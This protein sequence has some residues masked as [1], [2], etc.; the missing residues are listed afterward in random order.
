VTLA[1]TLAATFFARSHYFQLRTAATAPAAMPPQPAF[2]R[3]RRALARLSSRR[4]A[5][6]VITPVA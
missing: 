3:I 5:A 1:L 4:A 6:P 2:L